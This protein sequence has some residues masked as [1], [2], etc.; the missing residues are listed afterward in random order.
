MSFPDLNMVVTYIGVQTWA[1]WRQKPLVNVKVFDP[2]VR[3]SCIKDIFLGL[4]CLFYHFFS[5]VNFL[6]CSV[7]PHC[8]SHL[9]SIE[10]C[11]VRK[12][13]GEAGSKRLQSASVWLSPQWTDKYM[14]SARR[15]MGRCLNRTSIDAT[16]DSR[17]RRSLCE[18]GDTI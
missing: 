10:C 4:F 18:G 7:C 5:S 12:P 2:P 1:Q 3:P 13:P 17:D 16:G 8:W 15:C 6:F 9:Q 11:I 14:H